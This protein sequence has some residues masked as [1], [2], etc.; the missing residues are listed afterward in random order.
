ML[1]FLRFFGHLLCNLCE[2]F[3]QIE[4]CE[5]MRVPYVLLFVVVVVIVVDLVCFVRGSKR[6]IAL[7]MEHPFAQT[8]TL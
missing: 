3:V 5:C 1:L 8:A 2:V 7:T 6:S 4:S